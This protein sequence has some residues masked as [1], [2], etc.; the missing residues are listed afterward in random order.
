MNYKI[1]PCIGLYFNN[2]RKEP[3][4][5]NNK[6][7]IKYT[8][9]NNNSKTIKELKIS[10]KKEN[11]ENEINNK[12]NKANSNLIY[13]KKNSKYI[14]QELNYDYNLK[15][16]LK[17]IMSYNYKKQANRKKNQSFGEIKNFSHSL[18]LSL[19]VPYR[20]A[21]Y[22]FSRNKCRFSKNKTM[23]NIKQDFKRSKR[24]KFYNITNSE[25]INKIKLLEG[26]NHYLKKMIRISEKKL[27]IKTMMLEKF[28]KSK[29]QK[30]EKKFHTSIKKIKKIINISSQNNKDINDLK[31]KY[32]KINFLNNEKFLSE[33]LE[34]P[35]AQTAPI[36]YTIYNKY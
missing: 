22:I 19:G 27:N 11:K 29:N 3:S 18:S 34:E 14:T 28:L 25:E 1:K 35:K 31:N 10:F 9:N 23:T 26:E 17:K 33:F 5:K 2:I 32:N 15:E 30:E 21:K 36:P 24:Y 16:N 7:L 20:K 12:I 4:Y 13:L 6:A 8:N